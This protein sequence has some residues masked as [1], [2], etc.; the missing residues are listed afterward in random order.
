MGQQCIISSLGGDVVQTGEILHGKTSK[1][2]HDGKGVYAGLP[3]NLPVT[4]YHSLAGTDVTLPD[5]LEKSSWTSLGSD[6]QKSVIMGVRHKEQ[7]V[8]GVQFHPESI[9][10]AEGRAMLRNFLRLQGGTWTEN[11]RLQKKSQ[12]EKTNGE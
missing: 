2:S 6:G 1:L 4:R 3:Q 10:T 11:E 9:L 5:C 8:E 7:T 12:A